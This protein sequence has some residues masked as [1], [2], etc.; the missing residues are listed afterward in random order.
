[1][2]YTN[3]PLDNYFFT[4]KVVKK[5]MVQLQVDYL[6]IVNRPNHTFQLLHLPG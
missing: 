2:Q 1:M 3:V 6:D 5:I 4:I